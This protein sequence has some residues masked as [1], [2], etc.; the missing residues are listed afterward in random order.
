[1]DFL[2]AA[3]TE[4]RPQYKVILYPE[5]GVALSVKSHTEL[6]IGF[7]N[8][9]F[10]VQYARLHPDILLYGLE[11]SQACVLRCARRSEGLD[12]L[13]IINTDAR[14]M[15]KELFADETLT[16]IIMQFPCPWSGSSNAHRRVT[17]K[18][19][20]GSL[21]A[22]LKVG[23]EFYFVSDDEEYS[24]EVKSV[25]GSH[26]ALELV[27]FEIN[28]SREITT[29]YERKWLEQGKNI[30]VLRFKKVKAFTIARQVMD[31]GMHMKID[32]KVN[33]QNIESL[34]N[35]TGRN[36]D[37][38]TFWK[39]GRCFTDGKTFLLETLTSDDEF[40]QKF[41]INISLRDEGSLIR[42]DRTANAFLTPAVRASLEDV[43][44]RLSS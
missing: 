24:Q 4:A 38:K 2:R 37:N 32:R 19:F 29:K 7:G 14:Y 18:D 23:G 9:E 15:L 42:L 28:P 16:R 6:E 20:A 26:E 12:N 8:G 21:A 10:T 44:Q 31:R 39:F 22:V 11:I 35:V 30:H 27:S 13:R 17:A 25:L 43:S 33:S 34:K 1:M 36:R 40:E 3:T 41:Y 5:N